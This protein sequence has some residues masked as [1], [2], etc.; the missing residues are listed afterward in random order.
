[1][2]SITG[3]S[4]ADKLQQ[5]HEYLDKNY[6]SGVERFFSPTGVLERFQKCTAVSAERTRNH[7]I[8]KSVDDAVAKLQPVVL[9]GEG[10]FDLTA[11]PGSG[12]TSVLPF[13]FPTKKVVVAL[14]TPFDAWSA[15]QM[16]TGDAMLKLKGLTLGKNKNVCYTDS[17]LAAN[18]LLS[19]FQEYDILIVDECDSG[20]GVTRFLAD[21]KTPGKVLIRMSASHGRTQSGPS[22]A[23]PVTED[24]TMPDVRKDVGV[25]AAA[26]IEKASGRTLVLAPDAETAS[27]IA[28]KMPGAQ[29]VS[30]ATGLKKLAESM[31]DQASDGVFVADD[32]C[33]RGL[34]LNL[35]VLIDCQL[36][37]EH[38]VVRNI[39]ETELYQRKNRVGRNKPGW[40]VSPGLSTITLRE[41]DADVM[42]SNVMCAFAGL[43]QTGSETARVKPEDAEGLIDSK[44]EPITVYSASALTRAPPLVGR[45][46]R[47]RGSSG[48]SAGSA[49][50]RPTRGTSAEGPRRAS[51]VSPP[52]WLSWLIPQDAKQSISGKSY[53]VSE[54]WSGEVTARP[55]VM[56]D[57]PPAVRAKHRRRH[58]RELAVAESAPYAVVPRRGDEGR[59]PTTLVV[60][61]APP[62]VDLTV[63]EYHMD[64]PAVIR[65]RVADGADLPTIIP[66]GSWRHT[67]AGGMGTNWIARLEALATAELTFVESEFEVVC[68][69]WNKIVA[70][71]WV[72]RTPGLSSADNEDR[73]EFCVRYFQ[74]YFMMYDL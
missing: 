41:S 72:R 13:K 1:M 23:Y 17:Y 62:V 11:E 18:M 64:W 28:E 56:A 61:Q 31:V 40:Y 69:A 37:T 53:Y 20:K 67:S 4:Q 55:R 43:E 21:V 66:P 16:A 71:A 74:S 2:G 25:F 63:L 29:V 5:Y 59:Q 3:E 6:Q 22:R 9:G 19:N 26:A 48:S 70:Q 33:A 39:T 8:V 49:D 24:S 30:S 52:T 57:T 45:V 36:V 34:N 15:F 47:V 12:K 14:P 51:T 50:R 65:D 38:G 60:P 54:G 58:S 42:R 44:V 73:L 27:Q 32:V 35:D 46:S 68:R 7:V 10:V